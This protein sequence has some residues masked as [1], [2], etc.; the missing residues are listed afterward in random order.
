MRARY[1]D[2][3]KCEQL[4][5]K[6]PLTTST[7]LLTDDF[8]DN[9]LDTSK[10]VADTSVLPASNVQEQNG[11]VELTT[12]G[13]LRTVDEFDGSSMGQGI[14]VEADSTFGPFTFA[15][16]L[17]SL[18]SDGNTE[19]AEGGSPEDGLEFDV[20]LPDFARVKDRVGGVSTE[21]FVG[22]LGL[23]A[24]NGDTI[25]WSLF[26]NGTDWDWSMTNLSNNQTF[27]LS[28]TSSAGDGTNFV[29]FHGGNGTFRT[30]YW[31]NISI[32]QIVADPVVAE[33]DIKPGSETNPINVGSNGVIAV[34]VLTT[35]LFNATQVDVSTVQFAGATSI[36]SAYEDVDNDGDLDLVLHFRTQETNLTDLYAQLLADDINADG[37]LDS[38][39]KEASVTITG[40]T[41]DNLLFQGSD[42]VDLF[43]SGKALR[44][45]L[46]S[47]AADGLI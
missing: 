39:H 45:L 46:E 47:L 37:I 10:W 11:R 9:S 20:V 33:I 36:N 32:S 24:T 13:V 7:L 19:A 28:G 38:N 3:L 42:T 25:H 18:R 44:S 17:V 2:Y 43:L 29:S 34:A 16:A 8:N 15:Q 27:H 12:F 40:T 30:D 14:L 35:D 31:D 1:H 21:L 22:S 41:L 23:N 26:D 6:L 5:G 4:E